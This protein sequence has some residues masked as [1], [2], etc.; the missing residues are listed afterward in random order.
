MEQSQGTPLPTDR[1]S[2]SGDFSQFI[3]D[4]TADY[5]LGN[6]HD[7]QPIEIGYEDCN[8]ILRT[9]SGTYVTKIFAKYRTPEDITRYA[10][11]ME[12]VTSSEVNHPNLLM[13]RGGNTL[14]CCTGCP[15]LS[16]VL[17][18]ARPFTSWTER[19]HRRNAY[20]YCDKHEQLTK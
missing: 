14:R 1:L 6:L 7:F 3:T 11:I 8:V 13:N 17:C 5:D 19:L 9:T 16:W 12:A 15:L 4:L 18:P 2:F 20:R 10:A